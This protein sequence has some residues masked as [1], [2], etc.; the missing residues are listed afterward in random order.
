MAPHVL[1]IKGNF[2]DIQVTAGFDVKFGV[3]G[4]RGL[5][6]GDVGLGH[7]PV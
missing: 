7:H 2:F 3:N 1:G 4:F 5:D 6:I